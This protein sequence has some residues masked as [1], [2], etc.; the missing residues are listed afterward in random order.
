M[1]TKAEQQKSYHHGDLR[2]ALIDAAEKELTEKGYSGFTLRGCAR[3]AGVSHAAP[4]HHFGSAANLLIKLAA[5]GFGRLAQSMEQR[6]AESASEPIPQLMAA[7]IGYIEFARQN[8][9]LLQLMFGSDRPG[10]ED[11]EL[12][13]HAQLAFGVLTGAVAAVRG[14]DDFEN[15]DAQLAIA[16]AWSMVHGF[17]NLIN[18]GSLNFI[19]GMSDEKVEQFVL[20]MITRLR[21]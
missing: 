13:H 18:N 12:V 8:P 2:A 17:A 6:Q 10:S 7:G 4:A 1:P 9:A 11:E 15:R 21:F 20:E 5:T 3:R 19:Q 14:D 16:S